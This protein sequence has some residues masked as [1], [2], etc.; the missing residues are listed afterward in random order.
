M[1][2]LGDSRCRRSLLLMPAHNQWPCTYSIQHT[3][4]RR[5]AHMRIVND[6]CCTIIFFLCVTVRRLVV[7][8]KP[9]DRQSL[10]YCWMYSVCKMHTYAH[11]GNTHRNKIIYTICV[12]GTLYMLQKPI[13]AKTKRA[14]RPFCVIQT[15]YCVVL[16]AVRVLLFNIKAIKIK[17]KI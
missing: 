13:N 1:C 17:I 11:Y 5:R 2:V 9:P 6:C 3:F 12:C 4:E 8:R 7:S 14:S 15:R 16:L 10:Y